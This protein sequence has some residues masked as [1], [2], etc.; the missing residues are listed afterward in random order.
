M[1]KRKP[2][3]EEQRADAWQA[4][5]NLWVSAR[6]DIPRPVMEE[7]ADFQARFLMMAEEHGLSPP[8]VVVALSH[9]FAPVIVEH[10]EHRPPHVDADRW[11]VA[12][13]EAIRDAC[14]VAHALY[15]AVEDGRVVA[16]DET[17]TLKS[18]TVN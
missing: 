8:H 1:S 5:V 18:R 10:R 4:A 15:N 14:V 7:I 16:D 2:N 13:Y 17:Q 12:I 6:N 9:L 11:A 3:Y